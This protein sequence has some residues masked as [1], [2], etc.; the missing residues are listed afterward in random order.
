MT[1]RSVVLLC[2]AA[3]LVLALGLRLWGLNFGLPYAYHVDEPTYVSAALN[4]GA[5]IVGRQPNPTGFSNILFGEYAGYFVVGRIAGLFKSASDFERAYRADPSAFLLLGRLTSMLFGLANVLVVFWLGKQTHGPGTGLLAALLLAVAFLHVRDSHYGVPD[6]TMAFFATLSVATS[7]LALRQRGRGYL[8]L[9]VAACGFA[10]AVKWSAWPLVIVPALTILHRWRT[11]DSSSRP[12]K[13]ALD[14]LVSLLSGIGG[15]AVG[16]LQV[17]LN[18]ALYW[19]YAQ[20]ELQAGEGGGFGQWQIDTVPG[21]QFYFQTLAYG[22]GI[23]FLALAILGCLVIIVRAVRTKDRTS[24]VLV[25][26]P[27]LYYLVMGA[28]RHY[29]ARYALAL[30]PFAALFAAQAILGLKERVRAWHAGMGRGLGLILIL[31]A[32]IQPLLWSARHDMLLAREDT[33]TLAKSWIEA[34]IPAGS[35][36]A[37]DWPVYGPPLSTGAPDSP[38][39]AKVYDVTVVRGI[40][41]AEHPL[42]WYSDAGFDY[43]VTSSFIYDLHLTFAKPDAQKRAFYAALDTQYQLVREFSPSTDGSEPPFIFDEIYGPAVSLWQREQPG[44]VLKIYKVVRTQ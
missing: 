36:I 7:I 17:L 15:F 19:E 37:V 14:V 43:L 4:L 8:S 21:W 11:Q 42:S 40:G 25:S 41:L 2:L 44:P 28:T 12:A 23:A 29:F 13:G 24:I 33:R 38:P 10:I 16:G 22:L 32:V 1:S 34:N 27:L 9:A 31:A 6:I 35:K 26:F 39:A 5:G 18:P 20:R 30:V 3:I